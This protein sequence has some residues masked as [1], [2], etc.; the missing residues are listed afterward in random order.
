MIHILCMI[1]NYFIKSKNTYKNVF[2]K[3]KFL[4]PSICVKINLNI[5]PS[6]SSLAICV[7]SRTRNKKIRT[8]NF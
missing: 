3:R 8:T 6:F 7:P 2:S 5:C 1:H 4:F